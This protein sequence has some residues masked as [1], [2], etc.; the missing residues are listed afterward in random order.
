MDAEKGII[1]GEASGHSKWQLDE[2]GWKLIYTDGT[3]ASGQMAE[4][5]DGSTVEQVLWEKVNGC[6]YAF[7][8]NGYLKSGWVYDYALSGWYYQFVENG[9]QTGWCKDPQDNCT[10]YLDDATGKMITGWKEIDGKWYYFNDVPAEPTW[11]FNPETG[12]WDYNAVNKNK[13]YGAMLTNRQTPDGYFVGED[14]AWDGREK[15]H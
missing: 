15:Q 11:I 10:Y 8:A 12:A 5:P 13:P 14:G 4:Q 9:M 6:W 1:T 2:T 3:M 7:G